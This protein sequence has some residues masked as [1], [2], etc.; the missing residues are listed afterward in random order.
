VSYVRA[1]YGDNDTVRA[2]ASAT[3]S[4]GNSGLVDDGA[5]QLFQ[6]VD[7]GRSWVLVAS[8]SYGS[9]IYSHTATGSALFRAHY[10]GGKIGTYTFPATDSTNVRLAVIRA[11][12]MKF[13]SGH[14]SVKTTF[15]VQPA[16]SVAGLKV[17]VQVKKGRHWKKYKKIRF[18][19]NGKFVGRF[20][21]TGHYRLVLPTARGLDGYTYGFRIWRS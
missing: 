18:R 17:L 7:G 3:C 20:G 19:S 1:E 2:S 11:V 21:R 4:D 6:S 9:A 8:G 14:G 16:A 15:T 5:M 13:K 10:A 12:G